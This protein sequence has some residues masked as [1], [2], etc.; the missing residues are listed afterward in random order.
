LNLQLGVAKTCENDRCQ[1]NLID[2]GRSLTARYTPA[3]INRMTIYPGQ[4]V[5]I[6]MDAAEPEIAWRWH[7]V[8]VLE[9]SLE[10][11]SVE[12]PV[13]RR[14]DVAVVPGLE[15]SLSVGD[16]VWITGFS[17]TMEIHAK[18]VDNRPSNLEQLKAL[19]L[20]R[21]AEQVARRSGK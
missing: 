2:D 4:L 17:P 21:V 16:E 11:A 10:G 15:P 9:I 12:D 1:V 19:I 8:R 20:P 14:I 13:G 18:I 5:A 3:M 7:R 6:D